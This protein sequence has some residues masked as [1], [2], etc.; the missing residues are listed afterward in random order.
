MYLE[1]FQAWTEGHAAGWLSRQTAQWLLAV[2]SAKDVAQTGTPY[3]HASPQILPRRVTL[4]HA[5]L[6][7][8][9]TL[10]NAIF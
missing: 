2:A 3:T 7:I 8:I 9:A 1:E 10:H 5:T 4:H 6:H